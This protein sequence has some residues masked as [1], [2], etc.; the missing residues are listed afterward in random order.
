MLLLLLL[1]ENLGIDDAEMEL[2]SGTEKAVPGGSVDMT[3]Q[4]QMNGRE[5]MDE[6]EKGRFEKMGTEDG[7]GDGWRR[8]TVSNDGDNKGGE[9][10]KKKE[11]INAKISS[12]TGRKFL[13][14][15]TVFFFACAA[16]RL[17]Y[18]LPICLLFLL[19][20][21]IFLSSALLSFACCLFSSFLHTF[22]LNPACN[23]RSVG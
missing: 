20:A 4:D 8:R 6:K 22:W 19:P 10:K 14:R 18:G 12:K 1:G 9:G 23:C 2:P 15:K 21:A 13:Q 11:K 16:C 3:S 7:N 5:G 17:L